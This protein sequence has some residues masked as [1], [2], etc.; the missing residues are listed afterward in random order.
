MKQCAVC[1]TDKYTRNALKYND[2]SVVKCLK[3][4][5]YFVDE[6]FLSAKFSELY[7]EDMYDNYWRYESGFYEKHWQEMESRQEDI[8]RDLLEESRNI[9]RYYKDG[10]ILDMGCFKG[11]FCKIMHDRGWETKG[12][13][14]S[15]EAIEFG[16]KE[17]GLDLYCG[18]L[19]ELA[20]AS[21]SFDV[22][23]LW[24][25]I[26]HFKE[27]RSVIREIARVLKKK[28]L[29]V[30]KTQSQ[31]SLLTDIALL[32]HAIT[33]RKM[34]S[35]LD[36]F[37]SH[38]HLYRFNPRNLTKLLESEGVMVKEIRYDSAYIIKFALKSAKPYIRFPVECL[39]AFA[40]L[41]NKQ[42]KMTLYAIKE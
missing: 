37:Y 29:L 33:F 28:G 23:T 5:L 34:S 18:E 7:K 17:F 14:I 8:I 24:G 2:L 20:L 15:R 13:D 36:F 3:C 22:A 35:H 16:K 9:D 12:V 10:K 41:V 26:E 6:E 11:H 38:E 1:Q 30:I 25:V 39:E 21:G 19:K 27:P 42:D 31:T 4:G 40:K 32:L